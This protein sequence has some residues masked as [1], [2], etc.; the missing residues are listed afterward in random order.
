[1]RRLPLGSSVTANCV[2]SV[3]EKNGVV[4]CGTSGVKI[5]VYV[6]PALVER[7][8]PRPKIAAY[9]VFGVRGSSSM[10]FAPRA[11]QLFAPVVLGGLQLLALGPPSNRNVQV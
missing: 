6:A 11:E 9:T 7:Q 4:S 2:R 1:M 3:V 5:C 10:S 8:I